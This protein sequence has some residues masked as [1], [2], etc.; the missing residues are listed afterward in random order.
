MCRHIAHRTNLN[1]LELC[2]YTDKNKGH[3]LSIGSSKNH[4]HSYLA[5]AVSKQY[6]SH[7]KG[8]NLRLIFHKLGPLDEKERCAT[9]HFMSTVHCSH[10][11]LKS[12]TQV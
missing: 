2:I 10:F 6:Q 11:L 9:L 4:P 1:I 3:Q 7:T 5:S 8:N 12:L